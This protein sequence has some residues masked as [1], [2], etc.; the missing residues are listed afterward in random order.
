MFYNLYGINFGEL[1]LITVCFAEL[2]RFF[3]KPSIKFYKMKKLDL[4]IILFLVYS[5]L[6]TLV[7]ENNIRDKIMDLRVFCFWS[8]LYY[9]VNSY[10]KKS[11]FEKFLK[12][13]T[14]SVILS[15]VVIMAIY[16]IKTQDIQLLL[17]W[18]GR[19]GNAF[20]T[21]YII[22]IPTC[23]YYINNKL[24]NIKEKLFYAV[25]MSIM[26]FLM[27]INGSRSITLGVICITLFIMFVILLESFKS[28]NYKKFILN[29]SFLIIST[30]S[31]IVLAKYLISHNTLIF[32]R[33]LDIF[34]GT[35]SNINLDTREITNMNVENL[36][37]DNLL[38]YGIGSPMYMI[39]QLGEIYSERA[40]IDN[41]F[42]SLAYKYGIIFIIMFSGIILLHI[43]KG[44]YSIVVYK[45]N[46]FITLNLIVIMVL[47][48]ILTS[49]IITNFSVAITFFA[50]LLYISDK[51]SKRIVEKT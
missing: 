29:I 44:I 16:F 13:L 6:N 26:V 25:G 7:S 27:S 31:F 38:G 51:K 40:F 35:N 11:S 8:V 37:K 20:Q 32:T 33:L 50:L 15:S 17:D 23:M 9:I 4:S 47:G 12:L 19:Y 10:Y 21:L 34:N 3:I 14:D 2:M 1:I 45:S 41:A 5:F 48:A 28:L 49:Q 30:I 42:L 36:L 18:E 22:T 43:L 39:N 24:D 46:M